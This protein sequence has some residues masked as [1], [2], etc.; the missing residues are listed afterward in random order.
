MGIADEKDAHELERLLPNHAKLRSAKL[1]FEIELERNALENA[2]EPPHHVWSSVEKR[3]E[4]DRYYGSNARSGGKS[5]TIPIVS[6]SNNH[7][8]VHKCWR[9]IFIAI[10]ILSKIFLYFAIYYFLLYKDAERQK[11]RLEQTLQVAPS[12]RG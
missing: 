5:E 1:Q 6:A 2:T 11:Q 12:G 4:R 7:I 10:F 9:Y 8:R 3:I